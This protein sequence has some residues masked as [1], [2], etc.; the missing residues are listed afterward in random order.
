MD[1]VTRAGGCGGLDGNEGR[2]GNG[3]TQRR[4]SQERD[5]AGEAHGGKRKDA[6]GA[7][8]FGRQQNK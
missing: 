7:E 3:S 2:A 8:V 5:D 6:L 4:S 1:D